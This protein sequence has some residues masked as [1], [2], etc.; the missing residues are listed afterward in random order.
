[1]NK[2]SG[3]IELVPGDLAQ[4]YAEIGVDKLIEE[5]KGFVPALDSLGSEL[6][7]VKTFIAAIKFPRT[8]S[9]FLLG[10]KVNAF[11]YS[12]G[13]DQVKIDKF[14]KK[15]SKAKQE[16]LWERVAFSINAHDDKL[17][18]EII[19][20]LFS[21]LINDFID[22]DEF[23]ALAHA[24]NSLNI[25]T[26]QQLKELY[27][28][29][30]QDSLSS[31]QY[32]SFATLGLVDIDN[33]SIGTIGGGGPRYPLNQV[34]WKYV[35]II[36]DFPASQIGG[37]KIGEGTL[38]AEL[39]ENG[40]MTNQAYPLDYIR[41]KGSRYREV[42]LFVVTQEGQVL[43]NEETGL[44]LVAAREAV[45]AGLM[46][47]AI[48]QQIAPKYGESPIGISTRNM[49]DINVQR[50]SFIVKGSLPIDGGIYRP[51]NDIR[52]QLSNEVMK[53]DE[54]RYFVNI[55]D[56]IGRHTDGE[57]KHIWHNSKV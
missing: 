11:L 48:A 52:E 38:V 16:R 25:H 44:P 37:V 47:N 42:D 30:Q 49:E 5:S 27:S 55:I 7:Y 56:E 22:E 2:E 21:A 20:K 57:L 19:G 41:E 29:S 1:M 31:S 4:E 54:T 12:S 28:L 15:F 39:D 45:P 13:L 14:K 43:C 53:T 36:F 32:Y 17:K 24:T 46:P 3:K 6:P 10:K 8:L 34:G 23:F 26:V 35:G 51:R 50:W 40:Q 18:S 33:S 9:D